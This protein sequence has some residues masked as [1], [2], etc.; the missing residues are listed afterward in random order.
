[1]IYTH[2]QRGAFAVKSTYDRGVIRKPDNMPHLLQITFEETKINRLM[3]ILFISSYAEGE[4][5]WRFIWK[6]I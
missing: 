1:M 5:R 3:P 6:T 4:G 2:G